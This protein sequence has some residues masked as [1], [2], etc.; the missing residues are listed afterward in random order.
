MNDALAKWTNGLRGAWSESSPMRWAF[1]YFFFLLTGYYVLRPVRDALGSTQNLQL[2]FTG[3]FISMLLLQ[4][5]YGALVSR[6]PR[7]VFLPVVYAVFIACLLFF[8]W[9]FHQPFAWRSGAFFIWVAVFNLFAVS[10][11]WSFMA[12]VFSHGE[13]K[14][15]YGYIGAGGTLGGFLGPV[16]SRNLVG[17][18]GVANLLL[19]SASMLVMCIVCIQRLRPW[20]LAR[21]KSEATYKPGLAMGGTVLAG[22]RLIRE[23]P[24]L[25]ALAVLM[26]FGVGVGT[27][28]YNEQAAIARTHFV[29]A[30]SRTAYFAGIDLAINAITLL[31]QVLLTR[32]LLQ[33][34]G[35]AP[36][37][38]IPSVVVLLGFSVL[39]A[40]P[41]PMLVAVVQVI[42]RAGEFSLMKPA[43]ETLYTRVSREAR[44]KA[45][46]AIDT[47]VYRGGDLA[48]VWVH[49]WLVGFGPTAVFGVGILVA[50]GLCFGAW[51]VGREQARLSQAVSSA[52]SLR[53]SE[54]AT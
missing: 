9:A 41:L 19:L 30:A 44:Y 45:K 42:T 13:A 18:I 25:R 53:T 33:R 34:F 22:L 36:V 5:L 48:F 27:L 1:A 16:L 49:K 32:G 8:Y 52:E 26:F 29:D 6:Y 2:L 54:G 17:H 38:M 50:G 31:I 11:F 15:F 28:L 12:D 51:R 4:P 39:T 23:Q 47:V 10:V 14:R 46:A 21:E 24:L 37:L 3:T 20:A 7:R 35:V 40:S 43:R